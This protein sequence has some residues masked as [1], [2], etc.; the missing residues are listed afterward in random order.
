MGVPSG[1]AAAIRGALALTAAALAAAAIPAVAVDRIWI[2]DASVPAVLIRGVNRVPVGSGALLEA[3][4]IVET[5]D[6][7][8]VQIEAPPSMVIVLGP[9]TRA[10][11]AGATPRGTDDVVVLAG[12][13]KTRFDATGAA[14]PTQVD[15]GPA[16]IDST[17]GGYVAHATDAGVEVFAET[18]TQAVTATNKAAAPSLAL[19]A[20]RYA[21]VAAAKVQVLDRPTPAFIAA[22]PVNFR[23]PLYA[24]AAKVPPARVDLAKARKVDYADVSAWLKGA[25]T[26]RRAMVTR[27]RPRLTDD[28]FRHALDTEIGYSAEWRPILHPPP[29]PPQ[30]PV[31][32]VQPP[33][34]QPPA[35][36]TRP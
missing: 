20:D 10:W 11:F 35:A 5:A 7:A 30:A 22:M 18:G 3:G 31:P 13:I 33:P 14:P 8:R 32:P 29:P 27:F 9:N 12:W 16:R 4:D 21:V 25:P 36:G 17:A 6:D 19:G 24:I 28:A 2:T 1:S 34:D 26:L 23:S 15:F